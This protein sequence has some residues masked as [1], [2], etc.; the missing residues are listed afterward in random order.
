MRIITQRTAQSPNDL[1]EGV[2]AD[3]DV[4]PGARQELVGGDNVWRLL[5]QMH[6]HTDFLGVEQKFVAAPLE[7]LAVRV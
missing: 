5:K 6:Q 1:L 3:H 4:R 7:T 2:I